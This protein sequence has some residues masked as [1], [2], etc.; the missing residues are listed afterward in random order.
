MKPSSS[1]SL[2]APA[3]SRSNGEY[4]SLLGSLIH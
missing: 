4:G 2:S 1:L 3:Q